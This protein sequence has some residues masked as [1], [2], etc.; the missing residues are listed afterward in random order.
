[1]WFDYACVLGQD[2]VTQP[3]YGSLLTWLRTNLK[4]KTLGDS[5]THYVQD[6]AFEV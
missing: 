5:H 1:M 4:L 6:T 2:D 3:P